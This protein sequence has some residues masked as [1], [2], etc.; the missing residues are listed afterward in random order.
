MIVCVEIV[1]CDVEWCGA[2]HTRCANRDNKNGSDC[3]VTVSLSCL[4]I[5][6][7]CRKERNSM[8]A[9]L[10][11]VTLRYQKFSG[12]TSVYEI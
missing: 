12:S 1:Q 6:Y 9:Q 7:L 11:M 2:Y 3:I 8:V 5:E 4:W 10:G